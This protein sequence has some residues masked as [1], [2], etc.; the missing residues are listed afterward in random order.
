MARMM[1]TMAAKGI[2]RTIYYQYDHGTMGF[3]GRSDV[4]TYRE[5]LRTLLMS[6][7]M[8]N[9]SKFTDGRVAYWTAG[10]VVI[11]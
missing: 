2:A 11:I 1:I 5:T 6:G 7:T 9:A 8:L 10:G 3:Y 4:V